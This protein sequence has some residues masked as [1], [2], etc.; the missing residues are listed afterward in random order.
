[1]LGNTW[2]ISLFYNSGYFLKLDDKIIYRGHEKDYN[3]WAA[4]GNRG[5]SYAEVEKYFKRAENYLAG[6]NDDHNIYGREGEL[7]I[8]NPK[9]ASELAHDYIKMAEDFGYHVGDLTGI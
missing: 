4:L 5:W 3:N 9:D 2:C 7:D 1:M 8:N 6:D